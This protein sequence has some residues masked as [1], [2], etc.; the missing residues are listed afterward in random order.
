MSVKITGGA[1]PE[2]AVIT[3]I[4]VG[5]ILEADRGRWVETQEI[6]EVR[7][8]IEEAQ[9]D[10]EEAFLMRENHVEVLLLWNTKEVPRDPHEEVEVYLL[11]I[12]EIVDRKIDPHEEVLLNTILTRQS[13]TIQPG[14]QEIT[15]RRGMIK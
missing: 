11:Q 9:R 12:A 7:R 14:R 15:A 1:I 10:R 6:E 13:V 4:E 3:I 2:I 5:R 8:M